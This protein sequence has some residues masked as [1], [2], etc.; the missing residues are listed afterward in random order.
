[1]AYNRFDPEDTVTLPLIAISAAAMVGSATFEMFNVALADT[2][3]ISGVGL[4]I[5]YIIHAALLAWVVITNE[6]IS[7]STS[8][9]SEVRERIES[10]SDMPD[11]YYYLVA[12]NLGLVLAWPFV[13][14]LE[15]FFASQDLWRLLFIVGTTLS[16]AVIG[17]EL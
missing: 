12:A 3:T 2:T 8:G 16:T 10:R 17:Y 9:L 1:M 6:N 14:E 4:S 11:W 5:A 13:P 15:S 7:L